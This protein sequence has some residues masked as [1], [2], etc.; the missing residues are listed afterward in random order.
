MA[1]WQGKSFG[2]NGSNITRRFNIKRELINGV[3]TSQPSIIY[4]T[5][6]SI[7]PAVIK[8]KIIHVTK[9]LS[10]VPFHVNIPYRKWG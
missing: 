7:E 3:S 4:I 9:S 1:G 2:S 8:K 6:K 10:S 5:P